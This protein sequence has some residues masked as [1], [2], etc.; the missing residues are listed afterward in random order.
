MAPLH[1]EAVT[2]GNNGVPN[3]WENN[4]STSVEQE[5]VSCTPCTCGSSSEVTEG[6]L[7]ENI[8]FLAVLQKKREKMR[9]L[10]NNYVLK[11][12]LNSWLKPS[13]AQGIWIHSKQRT[14][15]K[16]QREQN[17]TE[18]WKGSGHMSE[19]PKYKLWTLHSNQS[20]TC[21]WKFRW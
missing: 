6:R 15:E 18:T 8:F 2:E 12:S 7:C 3:K 4:C 13:K 17:T 11:N 1:T 9:Y 21:L 14:C 10:V 16:L 19:Y 20:A 5:R